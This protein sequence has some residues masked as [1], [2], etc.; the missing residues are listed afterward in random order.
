MQFELSRRSFLGGGAALVA[1]VA[2][3]S[4]AA[5]VGA[6]KPNLKIG[7]LSD[8]H[9]ASV[10]TTK[11]YVKGN[12]DRYRPRETALFEKALRYFDS[13][14]ADAVVL[15][16]DLADWGLVSQMKE[17]T[18]CWWKVFPDGRSKKDGRKVELLAVLGNHDV[19]FRAW[20]QG[21]NY[22]I[23]AMGNPHR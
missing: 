10:A 3:E 13:R 2:S 20:T 23:E 14:G 6:G 7:V 1:S 4:Y 8:I 22:A 18:D 5:T 17:L 21:I 15:A 19:A 11:K 16:G 9:I 12:P